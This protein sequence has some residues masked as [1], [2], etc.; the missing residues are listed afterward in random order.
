[1]TLNQPGWYADPFHRAQTRWWSG[2]AWTEHVGTN[3]QAFIDP[4]GDESHA[5]VP[6]APVPETAP[7]MAAAGVQQQAAAYAAAPA[8][9]ASGR[10]S[11]TKKLAIV[12]VVALLVG[13]LGGYYLRGDSGDGGSSGG[14][15]T[16]GGGASS[17]TLTTPLL[18]GLASLD[19][20]EWSLTTLSIGP[21]QMDRSE[22]AGQG[23]VDAALDASHYTMTSTDSSADDPE[24][25]TSVTESWTSIDATCESSDGE[26]TKETKNPFTSD[27]GPV[28]SGLFDIVVP[29]GNAVL[30]GTETVAGVSAEHYTF[31]IEG[32]GAGTGVQVDQNSGELWVA[33]D[34]GYMLKYVVNASMTSGPAGSAE[35]EVNTI[36]MTLQLTSVNQPV[37]VAMPAACG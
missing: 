1:M 18:Q 30:V 5:M 2:A 35:S 10:S 12:G 8:V 22:M 17:G 11:A 21:T 14:G 24:P 31:T 28:L 37:N 20:Y 16:T 9:A 4:P 36:T 15:G 6:H 33:V 19:S 13:G 29:S 26:Y 27:V 25:Y 3:G 23:A 7:V 34:G 32:L